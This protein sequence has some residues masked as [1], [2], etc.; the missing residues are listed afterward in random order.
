[1]ATAARGGAAGGSRGG[2]G[3]D[4]AAGGGVAGGVTGVARWMASTAR[5]ASSTEALSLASCSLR[6]LSSVTRKACWAS[7]ALTSPVSRPTSCV[8][9]SCVFLTSSRVAGR[10]GRSTAERSAGPDAG[11]TL[12][13]PLEQPATMRPPTAQMIAFKKTQA[14]IEHP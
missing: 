12:F 2:G 4:K 14:R 6:L 13:L 9:V 10:G 11:A 3:G 1:G 5:R 7:R 8:C